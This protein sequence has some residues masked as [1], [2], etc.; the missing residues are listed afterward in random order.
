M[1]IV[2]DHESVRHGT[3]RNAINA[4][5]RYINMLGPRDRISYVTMPNGGVE[6]DFTHDHQQ[7][8]SALRRFTSRAQRE[9]T[10]RER[11][12]RSRLLLNSMTDY[13]K[14]LTSLKGP[15]TVV[16]LSSGVLN[17]RR[18][19]PITGPP[20]PCE[21]RQVYFQEVSAAASMARAHMYV[22]QPDDLNM[23]SPREVFSDPTASRFAGA[24]EDR[25]GLESLAG[26][27]GGDFMRI[28][29]PD[30]QTLTTLA[31]TFTGYYLAT[32][33]PE[34]GERNGSLHRAEVNVTRAGLRVRTHPEVLLPRIDTRAG[35]ASLRDMLRNGQIYRAL[36][37]RATALASAGA[38]GKVKILAVL[39]GIEPDV[40]FTEA[41]FGLID[42]RD[43]LVA[44]WTANERELAESP[45]VT[46]G[47]ATPGPYRL[48]VAAVDASGR[49]GV[50]EFEF[51]ARL[52]EADPLSLSG[53]AVGISRDGVF[54]PK[55]VFGSDQAAVAYF[56]IYGRAPKSDSVT[57]RLEIADAPE[58]R[59]LTT[60][61][62]RVVAQGDDRRLALGALPI[63]A[64]PP[65]DYVVRAI[66]S[67][68]GRPVGRLT[69]T[70]RKSPF[71]G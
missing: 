47:E 1:T 6:L 53:M 15:K 61:V 62:P 8:V 37:M 12:C 10:E 39:D 17:P 5:V 32:F 28:V 51:L 24:D 50:A 42:G 65:G 26:V 25:A 14:G 57:V 3:E 31:R 68:D 54:M 52:T 18:D 59:A 9:S 23:D 7:V 56:E 16:L 27:T 34:P 70:L 2:L 55:L 45:V 33:D 11:S 60:A 38:D 36:P 41:M 64:L 63:A 66:V 20:G 49:R 30:D 21:I 46:A 48:R 40:K 22:V 58:G 67:V 13:L 43:K 69:R 71:G 44:Q 29:G 35:G 19:A 4:A